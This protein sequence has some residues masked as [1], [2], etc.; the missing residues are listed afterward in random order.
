MQHDAARISTKEMGE[1]I[2][3][4]LEKAA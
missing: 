2:L 4:E 3:R 1:T